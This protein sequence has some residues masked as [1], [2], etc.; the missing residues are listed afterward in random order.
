MKP[1]LCLNGSLSACRRD[2]EGFTLA[3]MD[4]Q[5]HVLSERAT[6]LPGRYYTSETVFGAEQERIFGRRWLCVGRAAEVPEPG[7]F[8]CLPVG[9]ESLI[10][11]R[12]KD[13]RLRGFYNVCRHRGTRL[14]S[15][16]RGHFP[17]GI[18]CPYHA[19]TYELDGALRSAPLMA[20]VPWFEKTDY[21]LHAA[22]VSEWEGFVYV[23]LET[24]PPAPLEDAVRPLLGRFAPWRLSELR[25]ARRIAYDVRANWKL[26]FQNFSEC[27]H[28][29]PVHPA[30]AK[31][32]HY[33]SGANNLRD[34][35]V[36]GGY[37]TIN[38]GTESLT[39]SGRLCGSAIAEL[40]GEDRRRVYYYSIFPT[41]FLTLQP[42]FVMATRLTPISADATR[43][44]ADWLFPPE[45]L[46]EPGF[47]PS[48]GIEL[49][50]L[51]NRQDWHMCELAQQGIAS[52]A[53][54]PG[55]YSQDE[56]LL[57]AFDREYLAS[58]GE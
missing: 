56:S 24:H 15:E 11:V 34:G 26:I 30:L 41:A 37:M 31:L 52:R 38:D 53:Y 17:G 45:A 2:A 43:I 29:P 40:S 8:A 49:W 7:D 27:Y 36:L 57:A 51:T 14:C 10:V 20:D 9:R 12:G 21:P 32:S 50:D 4:Y 46:A 23:H 58:L 35:G 19:W 33:R 18:T 39:S 13:G 55:P 1:P 5:G 42:D 3:A 25:A 16:D 48:D 44:V 47:D 22:A 54:Q 6:T 28:C